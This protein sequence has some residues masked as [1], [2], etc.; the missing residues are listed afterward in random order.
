MSL[1]SLLPDFAGAEH[2][3]RSPDSA[4]AQEDDLDRS[5]AAYDKGYASGWEDATAAAERRGQAVLAGLDR[6][7]ED[8]GFTYHE[9]VSRSRAEIARFAQALLGAFLPG[10][11]TAGLRLRLQEAI[12]ALA[13]DALE[14]E[15][16]I[17]VPPELAAL[18]E[19]MAPKDAGFPLRFVEEPS[20]AGAQA[21]A[22]V[23]SR[24]W[25]VDFAG[26]VAELEG[27]MEDLAPRQEHV[28]GDAADAG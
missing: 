24:G 13:E 12:L 26:L 8:I 22:R 3:A 9:A 16:E 21:Y 19:D 2:A 23:G 20:L 17:I 6:A 14:G 28:E 10:L 4:A 27:A 25:H 1:A 15:V 18:I 5:R 7:V 11:A